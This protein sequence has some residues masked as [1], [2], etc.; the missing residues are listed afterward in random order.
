MS[1]RFNAEGD[2]HGDRA[3]RYGAVSVLVVKGQKHPHT[4]DR[5]PSRSIAIERKISTKFAL[6]V[7]QK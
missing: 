2:T 5:D 3:R 4:I 7:L 1:I 6:S